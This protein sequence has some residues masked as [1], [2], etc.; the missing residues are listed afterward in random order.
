M[1]EDLNLILFG[2]SIPCEYAATLESYLNQRVK[3]VGVRVSNMGAK[4]D[5]T[6]SSLQRLDQVSGTNANVVVVHLGMND[7]RKGIAADEFRENVTRMVRE[8]QSPHRRVVLST[9]TPDWN[10]AGFALSRSD[11]AGTSPDIPAY[12]AVLA[13]ISQA[14]KVRIADP[15]R[16]WLDR[17]PEL[18]TGLKDA[19]HPNK[20]GQEIICE[21]LYY[22]VSRDHVTIVWPF[23]GRYCSCNYHCPYCYVPS[24][25][26]KGSKTRYSLDEWQKGFLDSFGTNQRLT[27]YLS[28]G[29]PT[30]AR[31]F[32]ATLE[33]IG[34]HKQWDLVI[35]S[36]LSTDLR[37]LEKTELVQGGR[38]QINASF[39]P[40]ETTRE[41]FLEKLQQL[42]G[43]GIECPIVYVAYPPLLER[44]E[45]DISYF[46]REQFFVHVRRFRGRYKNGLYPESYSADQRELIARYMDEA[47]I[48]YMLGN[49][50]ALGRR[51][52]LGMHHIVVAENGTVELCD[53]YPG[54]RDLGNV[55]AGDVRLYAL[56]Q[57]FP[58]P[59]SVGAVDDV[60]NLV[61]LGYDELDG[62]HVESFARQGG[63]RRSNGKIIYPFRDTVFDESVW[64]ELF[65][66]PDPENVATFQW[67]LRHRIWLYLLERN[68]QRGKEFLSGMLRRRFR[69]LGRSLGSR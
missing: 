1:K 44:L 59:V 33:M 20:L 38:L 37:R 61:E 29:E 50:P 47:S 27:F 11:R 45:D 69:K 7:W 41:R 39:H 65:A 35:T 15:Y 42:R 22:I 63:L 3:T 30:L 8:L 40:T 5:T 19:I 53:E 43:M 12:N 9:I 67:Y 10:G 31:H 21:A 4:G 28:F 58:G 24:L 64:Q 62:N 60:A 66:V 55:I 6:R 13:E 54:A 18:S 51:S 48:R 32:V 17:L 52:Y 34:S 14:E 57:P 49:Q 25:V 36:N 2:D 56:P 46:G 16:L 23:N 26:N 68:W